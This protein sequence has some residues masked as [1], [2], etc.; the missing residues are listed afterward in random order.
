MFDVMVGVSGDG[1]MVVY[2]DLR[3]VKF[4][5]WDEQSGGVYDEPGTL[6]ASVQQCVMLEGFPHIGRHRDTTSDGVW[7]IGDIVCCRMVGNVKCHQMVV[8]VYIQP[9]VEVDFHFFVY[10][11][12]CN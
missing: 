4:L 8:D 9:V 10:L 3:L 11:C 12:I 6:V 7:F 5:L 2:V 1:M